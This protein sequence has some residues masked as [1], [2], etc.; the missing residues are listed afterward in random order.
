MLD[1]VVRYADARERGWRTLVAALRAHDL[2]GA[3]RA[4]EQGAEATRLLEELNHWK[5]R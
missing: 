5:P 3:R 4:N 2:D 1:L